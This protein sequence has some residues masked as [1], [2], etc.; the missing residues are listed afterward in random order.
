MGRRMK[1]FLGA[2]V[3]GLALSAGPFAAI[4]VGHQTGYATYADS[5]LANGA[6][7]TNGVT[8]VNGEGRE[9]PLSNQASATP[10]LRIR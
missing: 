9:S 1:T 7:Y 2:L 5:V 10:L 4:A 6:T 3:D 8:W